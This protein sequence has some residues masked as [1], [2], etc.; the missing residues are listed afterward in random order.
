MYIFIFS[1][2]DISRFCPHRALTRHEDCTYM[3]P[4]KNAKRKVKYFDR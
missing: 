2:Y 4:Y 1:Q 3:K